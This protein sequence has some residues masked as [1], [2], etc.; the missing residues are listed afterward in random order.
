MIKSDCCSNQLFE[1][2]DNN[3]KFINSKI[4]KS[5]L[6]E[7]KIMHCIKKPYVLLQSKIRIN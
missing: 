4:I 5:F 7:E 1:F 2:E 6:K 3:R